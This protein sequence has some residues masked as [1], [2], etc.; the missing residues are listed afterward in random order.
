M[1]PLGH[2][3]QS[4]GKQA[5]P[6]QTLRF[7][8]VFSLLSISIA[9]SGFFVFST[10]IQQLAAEMKEELTAA[11][12]IAAAG[13]TVLLWSRKSRAERQRRDVAME[14]ERRALRERYDYL[15]KYAN[16]IILLVDGG[17]RLVEANDR[18]LS[19][20]GYTRQEL[21]GLSL[22]DLR[23]LD[24]L[25]DLEGQ[26]KQVRDHDG[27]VFETMHRKSDGSTFAA[28]TSSR[29]IEVGGA[30]FC[31]LIIRDIT[32]RRQAEQ[33]VRESQ[34]LLQ[35]IVET[36]P[37]CIKLLDREGR[38][39]MMNQ[40]GLAMIEA[41][42]FEM[43][44]GR[45][46]VALVKPEYRQA[47]MKIAGEVF[48]GRPGQL[49]FEVVGL[50]GRE[51]WLETHAVPL[52]ND[53][54]EITSLLG[55][56]RDIT[57]HK[58]AE[59]KIRHTTRLYVVLSQINQ[60]IVRAFDRQSLFQDICRIIVDDGKF[61]MAWIGLRDPKTTAVRPLAFSGK[62]D[63]YL[64]A[65]GISTGDQSEGRGPTG[66]AILGGEHFICND[67]RTDPHMAPFRDKALERGYRSSAAVPLLLQGSVVA[68]LNLYS[69]E[70]GFFDDEEIKLLDEIG[71]DISFA[72]EN[73]EREAR[74]QQAEEELIEEKNRSAAILAAIGDGISIQDGNFKVVYQNE[75][76]VSIAGP[77]LGEY[78]Y[79]AYAGRDAICEGCPV[80]L[81]A[82]DGRVHTLDKTMSRDGATRSF[83]IASS[84]LR[85]E[86]GTVLAGIEAFREI[87]GRKQAEQRQA[88]SEK[89]YK[90]LV[91]SITDYIYTVTVEQGRPV[92]TTHGPGCLAV[93]GFTSEE[94]DR[95]KDLWY[96]IIYSEDRAAVVDH[97]DRILT[98]QPVAP[99]EHR[100]MHK[101]RLGPV[102]PEHARSAVQ[103]EE[104]AGRLR[105][106]DL[107]YH[108]AEAAR[109]AA[110]AG[111][112]D[113]GRGT[114]RRRHRPRL[115]QHPDRDHRVREPAQDETPR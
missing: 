4:A 50:K 58:L 67:I 3:H 42:S 85:D 115:Q 9:L 13:L 26:M 10:A 34:K 89:R 24:T 111:A 53:R 2:M 15:S 27:Y 18:A 113:G 102:D 28:E 77:H 75:Q 29:E 72:L 105:R 112:E 46:V 106:A 86:N 92:K 12:L 32:E 52:R 21:L 91:E 70:P 17:G 59:E 68:A 8:L 82:G 16:D 56:T 61:T 47:F 38:L 20:F 49:E 35:A 40:A 100:I 60:A 7:F 19:S 80:E 36:E 62:E 41:D 108:A 95:D 30:T 104:G 88:D 114:A 14:Y 37:E 45:P 87:T 84:V 83:E 97:A 98:G 39:L 103:R 31:Q 64:S 65:I 54:N 69:A 11:F 48:Q 76:H 78:C 107:E 74:R 109:G 43:V 57:G 79:R 99:F 90:L 66:S 110:P 1:G 33:Q 63:G 23:P 93:T 5:I 55:V 44:K 73:F 22:R 6:R 101:R 81:S 25:D 96:R 51:L 94:F 71:R